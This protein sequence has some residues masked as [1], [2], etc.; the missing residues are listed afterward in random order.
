MLMLLMLCSRLRLLYLTCLKQLP[1]TPTP[2]VRT[3]P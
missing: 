3:I 1:L 2:L